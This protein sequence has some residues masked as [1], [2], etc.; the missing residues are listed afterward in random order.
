MPWSIL[1]SVS[2]CSLY[3]DSSYPFPVHHAHD[4]SCPL[5]LTV[6]SALIPPVWCSYCSCSPPAWSFLSSESIATLPPF[7]PIEG[8]K[9]FFPVFPDFQPM[10]VSEEPV[11]IHHFR[12]NP[13]FASLHS[14]SH[15]HVVPPL[16]L[17]VLLALIILFPVPDCSHWCRESFCSPVPPARTGRGQSLVFHPPS[18]QEQKARGYVWD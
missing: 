7:G 5:F 9:W 1:T 17:T 15:V 12:Q 10:T 14:R 4:P 2:N 3:P 16:F 11:C 8:Q 13:V 18:H 6:L